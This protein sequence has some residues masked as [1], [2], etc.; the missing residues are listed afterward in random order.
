MKKGNDVAD[1]LL[2]CQVTCIARN[3]DC[4]PHVRR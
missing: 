3:G 2:F 1:K 4:I